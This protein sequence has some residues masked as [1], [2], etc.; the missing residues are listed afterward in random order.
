MAE[1]KRVL[2]I[3][4]GV[5]GLSTAYKCMELGMGDITILEQ[6]EMG[7]GLSKSIKRGGFIFDLGPHQIHTQDSRVI[8]FLRIL[9]KE[10]FCIKKKKPSQIL[11]G[12][13][14]NYPLR[15]NDIFSKL[16]LSVSVSSFFSFLFQ[17]IRNLFIKE[18]LETFESWVIHH[19]GKKMYQIY[20]KPYTT[21]VWGVDP[22]YMT[23]QCARERIAVQNLTDVLLYAISSHFLK[24]S[25]HNN[26]PHSPYQQIFYYPRLGI[27]QFCD[28]MVQFITGG[29]GEFRVGSRVSRVVINGDS[30][31][32]F[33]EN[34]DR[35]EADYLISTIPVDSFQMMIETDNFANPREQLN[36]RS[37]IFVLVSVN[38]ERVS[39][40][41][42]IYFP[43]KDCIFQRT[44]EF[45]NFSTAMAPAEQTGICFEIP[46]DYSDNIWQMDDKK[47]FER[48][49]EDS[50]NQNFICRD[51]V[52]DFYVVR[53]RYA[54]PTF[55]LGYEKKL[56]RIMNFIGQFNGVYT[57]GRQGFFK[58]I[59][60]DDVLIMGFE[61]AQKIVFAD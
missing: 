29:G 52:S 44:S 1:T 45:K 38:K 55:N 11:F 8:E 33:C 49:I 30:K 14:I 16:P 26:L 22:V 57:V 54:Y 5:A 51:W 37:L 19:F 35:F 60:I 13:E 41:H 15:L 42:W 48:C 9:L 6:S 58:Y 20:F 47:L 17:R 18:P 3:G 27:G 24:Y 40:N 31:V 43:D 25:K 28:Q 50:E 39:A 59:N 32:V 10:D 36:Y 53:E 12:R 2:I 4:G 23:A 46:C 34:G 21:K 7:G 61:T 56:E